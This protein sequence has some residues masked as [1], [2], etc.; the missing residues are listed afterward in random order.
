MEMARKASYQL[1]FDDAVSIWVR[2]WNGEFQHRIAASFDVNPGRVND[3][4]K[5]RRHR[6]S[7]QVAAAKRRA[8]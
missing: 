6:G 8:A 7:E 3:V 5:G 2:Y 1:T 4:I